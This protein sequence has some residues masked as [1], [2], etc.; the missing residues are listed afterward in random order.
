MSKKNQ[1]STLDPREQKKL[2]KKK[3]KKRKIILLV[4]EV[5]V[6]LIVLGMLYVW[7]ALNK[8]EKDPPAN[9]NDNTQEDMTTNEDQLEDETIEIMKGYEDVALFG[10]DN[11]FNGHADSGN[12][13]VIMIASI[14][15]D[16]KEVK[17][18]S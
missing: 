18:V 2:L 8:I 14:N 10:V 3:R 12:S 11:Y 6:L 1:Q 17:L 4:V 9:T 7:Q 5:L 15:N 13:D 16:T